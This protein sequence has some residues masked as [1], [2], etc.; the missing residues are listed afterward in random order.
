MAVSCCSV[1]SDIYTTTPDED[2]GLRDPLVQAIKPHIKELLT[3]MP[4]LRKDLEGLPSLCVDLLCADG[5]HKTS[6]AA[7]SNHVAVD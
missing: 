2:R 6:K 3:L 5:E 4:S 1:L 7:Q